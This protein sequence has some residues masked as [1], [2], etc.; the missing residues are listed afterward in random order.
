MESS[1]YGLNLTVPEDAKE[2]IKPWD[3]REDTTKYLDSNVDDQVRHLIVLLLITETDPDFVSLSFIYHF[4]KM[5]A[6]NQFYL[7]LV[8]R[9]SYIISI[10]NMSKPFLTQGEV[11]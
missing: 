2:I 8:S 1:V 11:K 4:R 9:K 7:S 6:S 5:Y 3:E 10:A